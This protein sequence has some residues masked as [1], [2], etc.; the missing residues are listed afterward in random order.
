LRRNTI[1]HQCT[2]IPSCTNSRK[3]DLRSIAPGKKQPLCV[4]VRARVYACDAPKALGNCNG[5]VRNNSHTC[6]T[7]DADS[8][9]QSVL[10]RGVQRLEFRL[11][12]VEHTDTYRGTSHRWGWRVPCT[13]THTERETQTQTHTHTHT[14]RGESTDTLTHTHT[15]TTPHTHTHTPWGVQ[16]VGLAVAVPRPFFARPQDAPPSLQNA[17]PSPFPAQ[18]ICSYTYSQLY[19]STYSPFS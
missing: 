1:S 6:K 14:H 17:L 13:H 3:S 10:H 12:G 8:V 11:W 5:F 19:M 18:Y 16:S 9:A 7:R 4:C 2:C 15:H